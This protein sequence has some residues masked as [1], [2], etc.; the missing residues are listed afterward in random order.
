LADG[1]RARIKTQVPEYSQSFNRLRST[2]YS[3]RSLMGA[4]FNFLKSTIRFVGVVI[5]FLMFG[6]MQHQY[7][8][9]VI[10]TLLIWS[11][12]FRSGSRIVSTIAAAGNVVA[13]FG[14][15]KIAYVATFLVLDCLL[16]FAESPTSDDTKVSLRPYEAEVR[17]ILFQNEPSLLHTVDG[18]LDEHNGREKELLYKLNKQYE[19]TAS[20]RTPSR[21]AQ[22]S[23]V[24]PSPATASYSSTKAPSGTPGN[25]NRETPRNTYASTVLR[26]KRLLERHDPAML[27]TL[28][29][30]L[31][32][33]RGREQDLLEEIQ[34]EYEASDHT[35]TGA[36]RLPGPSASGSFASPP[37]STAQT[38][39]SASRYS[40]SGGGHTYAGSNAYGYSRDGNGQHS[41]EHSAQRLPLCRS[42]QPAPAMADDGEADSDG[43]GASSPPVTHGRGTGVPTAQRYRND[44]IRQAQEEARREMQAR[45]DA[46]WGAKPAGSGTQRRHGY[47]YND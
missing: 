2:E 42:T 33:Y 18:L 46:R 36:G 12:L 19:R 7:G 13:W 5:G 23:S 43:S 16:L 32:E 25:N 6:Y 11:Y 41:N 38:T 21:S 44:A 28:D 17:K 15:S 29:R 45:I 26:I 3:L 37:A 39:G 30:M 40:Y 4:F 31:E 1:L 34:T 24:A 35:P 27:S 14:D 10:V 20:S 22:K 9:G 47:S 8:A